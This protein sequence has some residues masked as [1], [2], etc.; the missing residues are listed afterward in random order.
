M[1][2]SLKILIVED[3]VIVAM[4]ISSRLNQMGYQVTNCVTKGET[5]VKEAE[6]NPPDLILMDIQLKGEMN[7][8]EAASIIRQNST[9]DIIFLS[10]FSDASMRSQAESVK[11]LGYL[12]KPFSNDDL[13][14]V[15]ETKNRS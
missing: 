13:Q 7:G 4:D 8:I 9:I 6:N 15:I 2:N 14:A 10:A 5:A 12:S 11:P 3:N 1:D